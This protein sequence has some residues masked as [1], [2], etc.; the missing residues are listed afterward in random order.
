MSKKPNQT[1]LTYK[2]IV[3]VV[4]AVIC[5]H[6]ATLNSDFR[7]FRHKAT[8]VN[9]LAS[10]QYLRHILEKKLYTLVFIVLSTNIS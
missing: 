1:F 3:Q 6:I 5:L 7:T 2:R 8:L 9:R 10:S 4:D